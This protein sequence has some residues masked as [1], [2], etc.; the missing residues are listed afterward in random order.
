LTIFNIVIYQTLRCSGSYNLTFF[1]C[2]F[3][4]FGGSTVTYDTILFDD[5]FAKR[6][7]SLAKKKQIIRDIY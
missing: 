4:R 6:S 2:V 1:G 5:Y 3:G 7:V